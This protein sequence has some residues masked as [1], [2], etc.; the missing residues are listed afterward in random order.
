VVLV[1]DLTVITVLVWRAP[2]GSSSMQLALRAG[3]AALMVALGL[4]VYM[5]ARGMVIARTID[6]AA[7]FAF[8]AT[9]K[10]GHAATM[11]GVLVLPAL[12]WLLAFAHRSEGFRV[13]VIGTATAGYVLLAFVVVAEALGGIDP[14]APSIAPLAATVAGAIGVLL[15]LA[16]LAV[17]L[18][19]IVVRSAAV[20]G[21]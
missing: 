12:A 3:F 21:R 14:L 19:A 18:H 7:A 13:A 1:A 17:T 15:L 16:A 20:S 8:S 6:P 2:A 5:L 11:H 4:G 9:V 10:P